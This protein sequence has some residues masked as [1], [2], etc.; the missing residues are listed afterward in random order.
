[1]NMAIKNKIKKRHLGGIRKMGEEVLVVFGH[2]SV[3]WKW[4]LSYLIVML[5]LILCNGITFLHSKRILEENQKQENDKAAEQIFNGLDNILETMEV[6]GNAV[7]VNGDMSFLGHDFTWQNENTTYAKYKLYDLLGRYKKINGNYSEVLLYFESNDYIIASNSANVSEYYRKIYAESMGNISEEEWKGLLAGGYPELSLKRVGNGLEKIFFIKTIQEN[8]GDRAKVNILFLYDVSYLAG[9]LFNSEAH[10]SSFILDDGSSQGI[11][12]DSSFQE[13]ED[14]DRE[15]LFAAAEEKALKA[16]LPQSGETVFFKHYENAGRELTAYWFNSIYFNSVMSF[17][18]NILVLF[19]LSVTFSFL[20]MLICLWHNYKQVRNLLELLKFNS[21]EDVDDNEFAV[22]GG[23]LTQIQQNLRETGNKLERQNRF[24]RK[25]YIGGLLRGTYSEETGYL[26]E[27]YGIKWKSDEFCVLLFYME[28]FDL[29]TNIQLQDIPKKALD[30]D[31]VRFIL[32]NVFSELF[33]KRECT[34]YETLLSGIMAM[35]VNFPPQCGESAPRLVREVVRESFVF[36]DRHF[37]IK[38]LVAAGEVHRGTGEIALS[39]Q[40][41]VRVMEMKRVYG[42]EECLFYSELNPEVECSYYY[43]AEAEKELMRQIQAGCFERAGNLLEEIFEKN[44]EGAVSRPGNTMSYLFMDI[45]CT[46]LK[47]LENN[48]ESRSLI[49]ALQPEVNLYSRDIRKMKTGLLHILKEVCVFLSV[50]Q[51]FADEEELCRRISD[52]IRKNYRDPNISVTSIADYFEVPAVEMSK[53][54]RKTAG[55]KIPAVIS[56]VR[57]EKAK[58]MLLTDQ[59]NINEIAEETGFGTMRTF[60]RTYKQIE[61]MTP[62]QWRE[63]RK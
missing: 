20:L 28:A 53:V 29:E 43:P 7:L 26:Q 23:K 55:M 3:F 12:V 25:E 13:F 36:I 62:S 2:K 39:C 44:M 33:E 50:K 11:L 15:A 16:V 17:Q 58:E 40:E 19:I 57:L 5:V 6:F 24:F 31:C 49:K 54:F 63:N 18:R 61:G 56:Q 46:V 42:M 35:V 30:L 22:I 27:T 59:Y 60:L 8:K 48:E 47:S 21:S 1:M 9:L 4:M 34:V 41:A 52:Y 14:T 51:D 32:N 45:W 10:D 38:Y 37:D